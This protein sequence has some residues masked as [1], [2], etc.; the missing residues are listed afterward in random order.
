MDFRKFWKSFYYAAH[1]IVHV[2]KSEQNFRFHLFA[3]IIV[4]V[5]SIVTGLT[6]YEWIIIIMLICGMFVIELVNAA[7]ERVVDL[8]SPDFHELA[9]RAKDL[10]A[11]ACLVCAIC[12]AIV[13]L[14]IFVPKWWGILF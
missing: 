11:G 2:I 5:A 13:G 3:A 1:G 7:I 12:T 6:K 10:A 9:L 4:L 14:I 8:A